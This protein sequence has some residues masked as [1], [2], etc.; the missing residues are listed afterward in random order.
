MFTVLAFYSSGDL[1]RDFMVS[2]GLRSALA[3]LRGV[4]RFILSYPP[5]S[6]A[7]IS[8]AA[9]HPSPKPTQKPLMPMANFSGWPRFK[10][11]VWP[12]LLR[13]A[14][15]RLYQTRQ[16]SCFIDNAGLFHSFSGAATTRDAALLCQLFLRTKTFNPFVPYPILGRLFHFADNL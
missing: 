6:S 13:L 14:L 8:M 3:W 2:Y 1:I 10:R 15:A 11:I 4:D 5:P 7:E 9:L 12:T 16:S